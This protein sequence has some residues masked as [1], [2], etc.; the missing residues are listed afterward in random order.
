MDR[1]YWPAGKQE[2]DALAAGR[3]SFAQ[4]AWADGYQLLS[5]ADRESPLDAEDLERVGLSAYLIGRESESVEALARA[6]QQ[7]AA[8]GEVERAA[9][10]GFWLAFQLFNA[11]ELAR[12]GGWLARAQRLLD[13]A[14][15]DCVEQGYVLVPA[16]HQILE[17]EGDPT[18]ACG[19]FDRAIEIGERYE[20]PTLT[21]LA[22]LG[23]AQASI[24]LGDTRRAIALLDEVMVAV[25]AGEVSPAVAGVAYCA[26][27]FVCQLTFDLRRAGEW[28]SALSLWCESQ[29]DL[30]PYRGQC[31]VH[32]AELMQLHGA[33]PD[34]MDEA[35]Q[36][37]ERLSEPPGQPAVGMA[38][39]VQGE[40][41]RL[42]GEFAAAESAYRKAN[43]WGHLPQPGLSL[44]RLA[45]GRLA[46]ATTGIKRSLDEARGPFVRARLLP[47]FVEILLAGA[48]LAEARSAAEEL[49]AIAA[50]ADAPYLRA[51][52]AHSLGA[53]LLAESNG[54]AALEDLRRAWIGWQQIDAPFEAGRARVLIGQACRELGDE[55]ACEMELDA[56]QW[57]FRQLGAVPE[58][59][60]VEALAGRVTTGTACGLTARE[61][62]V[63]AL[64]ATGRTNRAISTELVI[65]EKTV[66]RHLSNIFTKLDLPSRAAATAYAYEH[67][68]V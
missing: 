18:T 63:L 44:L 53:V 62:Q 31:L 23:R 61:L 54:K 15:R 30:V 43:H 13:D 10:C 38:L 35:Q 1:A 39:Y 33:W 2:M 37:Y 66:A 56:A 25:T 11:G 41:H 24:D 4:H 12:G 65:S 50:D 47:A 40:L 6:Y 58:L 67:D 45:Q 5:A 28:T 22:R 3:E 20:D 21:A 55:D 64:V 52:C 32:R 68:L 48:D 59:A 27:I 60:R 34:A 16:A 26:T 19:L 42:R 36:A 17:T 57:I 49:A 51:S 46:D 8:A 9:R 14:G 29:P 7:L